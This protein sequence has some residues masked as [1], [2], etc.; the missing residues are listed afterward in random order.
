MRSESNKKTNLIKTIYLPLK[1]AIKLHYGMNNLI[2]MS[3]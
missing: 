3:I 2:L 1:L